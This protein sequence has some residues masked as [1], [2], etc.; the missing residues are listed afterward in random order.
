[1]YF[2]RRAVSKLSD[3]G[4]LIKACDKL[5]FEILKLKRNA[6]DEISGMP[7]SGLGR[8]HILSTGAHPRLRYVDD[9]VLLCNWYPF[10]FGWHH[11]GANDPRNNAIIKKIVEL[12]GADYEQ[13]L[14]ERERF[15]GRMDTLYLC[16]IKESMTK[17]LKSLTTPKRIER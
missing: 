3:R 9:N 10:H 4:K 1:M 5:H 2:K 11:W 16:A 17:E 6:R 15:T 8:F 14:L 13:K 12:R 7:A